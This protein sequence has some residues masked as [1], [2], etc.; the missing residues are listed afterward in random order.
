MFGGWV[1]KDLTD[2]TGGTVDTRNGIEVLR[3][4][5]LLT[6]TFKSGGFDFPDHDFAIFTTGCDNGVVEG[7]P[8]GV[9]DCA[10]MTSGQWNDIR[11][12][13]WECS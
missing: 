13:R 8:R 7:R 2:P 4:P 10:R 1:E 5:V 6:P 3:Y 11:K 12:P 9:Q